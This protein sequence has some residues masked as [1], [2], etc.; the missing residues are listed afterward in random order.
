MDCSWVRLRQSI[1]GITTY[2]DVDKRRVFSRTSPSNKRIIHYR[3]IRIIKIKNRHIIR[4]FCPVRILKTVWC[5]RTESNDGV[6]GSPQTGCQCSHI[7]T[8]AMC[9]HDNWFQRVL[10]L[11]LLHKLAKLACIVFHHIIA[12]GT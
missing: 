5:W 1:V 8:I 11:D 10:L 12:H 9:N 3:V 4:H 2:C 7:S 6:D